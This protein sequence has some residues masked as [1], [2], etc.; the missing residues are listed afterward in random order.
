MKTFSCYRRQQR[1][2]NTASVSHKLSEVRSVCNDQM[3]RIPQP[4][5]LTFWENQLNVYFSTTM[6]EYTAIQNKYT[7]VF[8]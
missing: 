1:K 8:D 7:G 6:F 3:T 2:Y 5:W 4:F